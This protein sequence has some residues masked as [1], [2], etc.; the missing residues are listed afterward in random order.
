MKLI[1]NYSAGIGRSGCFSLILSL[2][3]EMNNGNGPRDVAQVATNVSQQRKYLIQDKEQLK[4]CYDTVL[5]YAQDLLMKS[6]NLVM[7][8]SDA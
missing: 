7:V 8:V 1:L 3:N 2:V 5:Y 4:F 6:K